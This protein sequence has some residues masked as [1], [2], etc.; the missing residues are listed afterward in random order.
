MKNVEILLFKRVRYIVAMISYLNL[1]TI[2]NL[3]DVCRMEA[4]ESFHGEGLSRPP[5]FRHV[6]VRAIRM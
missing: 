6:S 3:I 5:T 1:D 2:C 4:K